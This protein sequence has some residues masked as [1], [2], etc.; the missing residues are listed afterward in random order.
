MK[1][2]PVGVVAALS[3]VQLRQVPGVVAAAAAVLL[4]KWAQAMSG[5][6]CLN[7]RL[8]NSLAAAQPSI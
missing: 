3:V 5:T 6:V 4:C 2:H 7:Q 1:Q 8:L